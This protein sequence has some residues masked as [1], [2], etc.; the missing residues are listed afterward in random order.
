NRPNAARSA[1]DV[2][3]STARPSA[4][5]ES[6]EVLQKSWGKPY[7]Y[8][9]S[10]NPHGVALFK[11]AGHDRHGAWF[12][13]RSIHE[14]IGFEKFRRAMSKEFPHTLAVE[15]GPGAGAIRGLA[16]D[17]RLEGMDVEGVG[18]LEVYLLSGQMPKPVTP[19]DFVQLLMTSPDTLTDKSAC[20]VAGEG[21]GRHVP[22]SYI[23]VSK[24]LQYADAPDRAG[25]WVRGQY[26]SV[27]MIREIPLHKRK[28]AQSTPNLLG[29]QN[30]E[31]H[32]GRQRGATIGAVE[33]RGTEA[34]G[35]G[36]DRSGEGSREEAGVLDEA[37]LNPVEWIMV[38]RSDPGGGIP[39]FLV[40]RGTPDAMLGD[41]GK[42]LDW[43][44]GQDDVE[45][46]DEMLH[47]AS[48]PTPEATTA[49]NAPAS[50]TAEPV[51]T[52]ATPH[53][54][55]DDTPQPGGLVSKATG[56]VEAGLTAYA[57]AAVSNPLH[58]YLHPPDAPTS[59]QAS[60]DSSSDSASVT[61]FMSAEEMRRM[62]TAHG[63][64]D[65]IA[66]LR[67]ATSSMDLDGVDKKTLDR[68][69]KEVQK[70]M[71]QREKLDRKLT[72]KREAEEQK[73]QKAKEKDRSEED[74]QK[75]R[76]EKEIQKAESRHR[77]EMEKLESKKVKEAKK[78]EDKRR[79]KDDQTKLSAVMRE[80]DDSRSQ[81]DMVNR[82]NKL[83]MERMEELQKENTAL[84]ARQG[85]F[86]PEV[87]K[88]VQDEGGRKR[89]SSI[90]SESRKS[91]EVME[92][93]GG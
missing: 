23:I 82:E 33:S 67:S 43:A 57:P 18:R 25:S 83:L 88:E 36:T 85:K 20:H 74:K 75:E 87:L 9:A 14:G 78:V 60:S 62:S 71:Q 93:Q 34:R 90:K 72:Q 63:R 54:A 70:L 89:S 19:R 30:G 3:V 68:H 5:H 48:E 46:V 39:R 52:K 10:A 64:E 15:G 56:A 21:E 86:A 92:N 26:E 49:P 24:P 35:D 73:L 31:E 29:E 4:P 38:T 61:S 55:S 84:A 7:K 53:Q 41:I 22:R 40:D 50:T 8:S 51:T 28:G 80:R 76:H 47:A 45:K 27:E 2:H 12:A 59:A 77:R 17:Q 1:K 69:D 16:A 91:K 44:A 13:R 6:H 42:F 79:K 81:L 66:S 11:M 65:E 37:E 32:Q 58:D